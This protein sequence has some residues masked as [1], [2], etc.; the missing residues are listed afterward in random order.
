MFSWLK[1][2]M[3]FT[4]TKLKKKHWRMGSD[5]AK[6]KTLEHRSTTWWFS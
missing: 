4:L 3:L 2:K 1:D 5:A 6:N